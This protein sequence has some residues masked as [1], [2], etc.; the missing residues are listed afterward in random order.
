MKSTVKLCNLFQV[1]CNR[2]FTKTSMHL[3]I[4]MGKIQSKFILSVGTSIAGVSSRFDGWSIA[5]GHCTSLSLV[6]LRQATID[7][8]WPLAQCSAME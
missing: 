2:Q 5:S 3:V 4:D 1:L 7:D 8:V 6:K